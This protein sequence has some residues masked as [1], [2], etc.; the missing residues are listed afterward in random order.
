MIVLTTI[1]L[2]YTVLLYQE[3]KLRLPVE[4]FTDFYIVYTHTHTSSFL[5][6]LCLANVDVDHLKALGTAISAEECLSRCCD[7]GQKQCQYLWVFKEA[8]F[9]VGCGRDNSLGCQPHLLPIGVKIDSIYVEMQYVAIETDLDD[10]EEILDNQLVDKNRDKGSKDG[11]NE[12]GH[13]PVADAGGNMTVQLPVDVVHLYGN[14]SKSDQVSPK[15]T[16]K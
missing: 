1:L 9:S 16:F 13:P 10:V 15:C 6:S 8:C 11:V 7:L 5:C 14:G 3:I 2:F 4:K 12:K